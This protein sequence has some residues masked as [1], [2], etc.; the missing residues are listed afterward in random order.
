MKEETVK[1]RQAEEEEKKGSSAPSP[2][3]IT[4]TCHIPFLLRLQRHTVRSSRSGDTKEGSDAQR[5]LA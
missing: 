5:L 1:E 2:S 3:E 4:R